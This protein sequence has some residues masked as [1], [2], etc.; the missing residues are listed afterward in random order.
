M[1]AAAAD[2]DDDGDNEDDDKDEDKPRLI[3]SLEGTRTNPNHKSH[4]K[5]AMQTNWNWSSGQLIKPGEERN[6]ECKPQC[7][8]RMQ[9]PNNANL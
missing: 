2:D 6:P 3:S 7:K 5:P 9:T 1:C 4:P 8:P